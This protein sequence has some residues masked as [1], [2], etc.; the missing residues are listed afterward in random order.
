MDYYTVM[1]LDL[2]IRLSFVVIRKEVF[3]LSKGNSKR[4]KRPMVSMSSTG[5][6]S[7]GPVKMKFTQGSF[8]NTQKF[9]NHQ[10][11][12]QQYQRV[13]N[14]QQSDLIQSQD[15]FDFLKPIIHSF[16]D[17]VDAWLDT[18]SSVEDNAQ[19]HTLLN[20]IIQDW[21]TPH[22]LD[23]VKF[24]NLIYLFEVAYQVGNS[25]SLKSNSTA[26][27]WQEWW[28]RYGLIKKQNGQAKQLVLK[29][30][31]PEDVNTLYWLA[32][33]QNQLAQKIMSN[34]CRVKLRDM[35]QCLQN[36]DLTPILETDIDQTYGVAPVCPSPSPASLVR[37]SPVDFKAGMKYLLL[38]WKK[39]LNGLGERGI[40]N[41]TVH[42]ITLPISEGTI[43]TDTF[44]VAL[45][46]EYVSHDLKNS[47]KNS[48]VRD[49]DDVLSF[50][51]YAVNAKG[52]RRNGLVVHNTSHQHFV[53]SELISAIQRV[54]EPLRFANVKDPSSR[55][56]IVHL[57]GYYSGVD[58]SCFNGWERFWNNTNTIVLK[59]NAPFTRGYVN[60]KL[61]DDSSI[62]IDLIDLM[63]DAPVG[64]LKVVGEM[65][66]IPK[67]NTEKF[68]KADGL[69][70]GF[71]KSHMDIFREKR[72]SD[73][74]EYAMNDSIIT[75]EYALFL[76]KTLGRIPKTLGS[77]AASE[78]SKQRQDY[79]NQFL[80]D[81]AY[82][83]REYV[84]SKGSERVR[85]G[86]ADLY[87]EACKA[88]FGGHNVAYISGYGHGRILDF[89]LTS[90]YNVGGHLLPIIDYSDDNYPVIKPSKLPKFMKRAQFNSEVS[91]S[92][93][94]KDCDF[95][96][97]GTQMEQTSV[98]L[99]GI[100]LF[101]IDYPDDI[102]MIV[103]PS[104]STT[105]APIYVKHYVDWCTLLDA[106]TAWK[107]GASVH[108]VRLRIPKQNQDGLNVFGDFQN[109]EIKLRNAAKAKMQHSNPG[110]QQ[111]AQA[112]GEQLLHKL[113]ANTTFG[114]TLQG[115]GNRRS[116]NFD[117]YLMSETPKS[118]ITDPLIGDNYTSF[119][120]YLVCILYDASN[121]C[122]TPALQLN[123][124]TDGLSLSVNQNADDK[125]FIQQMTEYFNSKMEPFYFDRL[126]LAG[127]QRGFELKA[128][129]I[130]DW[131]NLRTRVNGSRTY[132][133]TGKGIFATAS[134][135]GQKS[136][137]LFDDVKKNVLFI[138]NPSW[139][140]SN[141]SEMKFR[142]QNHYG[143]Q[144]KFEQI[145][146]VSLSYDFAYKPVELIQKNNCC[147]FTT[148]PYSNREEH[149]T[150]KDIG[151]QLAKMVPMRCNSENFNLFL[152]T[153]NEH[154]TIK[155]SLT[156]L[157][158]RGK[159]LDEY[160]QYCH[161]H[162]VYSLAL[163]ILQGNLNAEINRF[164]SMYRTA[165]PSLKKAIRRVKA[166]QSKVNLVAGWYYQEAIKN[167]RF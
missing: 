106:Y 86:Q 88:M 83:L 100:G 45:D 55:H 118:P 153:M 78:V 63:N 58:I 138:K 10:L 115:T 49:T 111:F 36:I 80:A 67:I 37:Q 96:P 34:S 31:K 20:D 129:S 109:K 54:I 157:K 161:R 162:Y 35:N 149:D 59:K 70:V 92:F 33:L 113:T 94:M 140:I 165:I 89:D 99:V 79:P 110:S 108:V 146:N 134:M 56:A 145:T 148:E 105:G 133:R 51:L 3:I 61:N 65:V 40:D 19:M 127:K 21:I 121:H 57:V 102:Q 14:L 12:E 136:Y 156:T 107:H 93:R 72:P 167:G 6:V 60:K 137:D 141:L 48:K 155:R 11:T 159:H 68:D 135:M 46:C 158:D 42:F 29:D 18:L 164:C 124:T 90:A 77:Y 38:F 66:G 163:G 24:L 44:Y 95:A 16:S 7:G 131:F 76:K 103:T 4:I 122:D 2:Y 25:Q 52:T 5:K 151:G 53:Q 144:E 97:I 154:P 117:T 30:S 143:S 13:I 9:T 128:N 125:K 132:S 112:D 114:K 17:C 101:Q 39:C 87:E 150:A 126:H 84:E 75:L 81:P 71:Y 160:R 41:K 91:N 98:F 22:H 73:F 123:I 119:T 27:T 74:N 116:R 166:G 152:R 139:R 15:N 23:N 104:H 47:A 1:R 28:E 82:P 32:G 43:K 50:Q 85:P 142:L 8:N 62:S 147:Y 64:G 69:P 120:R 130:D 26:S